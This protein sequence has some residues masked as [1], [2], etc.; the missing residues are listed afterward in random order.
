MKACVLTDFVR[1]DEAY[2]LCR[3]VQN[4][5]RMISDI[6]GYAVRLIVNEKFNQNE[7][8]PGAEI[9][10]V[11]PG[12]TGSNTVEVTPESGQEIEHLTNQMRDALSGVGVVLTH[13]L[14]FQANQ[15][16]YHVACRR[17][18]RE[19]PDIRWLHWVH[20]IGAMQEQ[21]LGPF[22]RE[23]QGPFP[24]SKLV[25]MHVE[26]RMRKMA[27]FG[28]QP[29]QTVII[30]NP[31]DVCE[32]YHPL[33]RDLIDKHEL[34]H[35]DVV[36]VYPCRLDRGK[37]PHILIEIFAELVR[38][39]MDARV[40]IAD[41]HSLHGDK[42]D[43]R[44]E[45]KTLA[46]QNGVPVYFVSE[47][48][49]D[50]R[51]EI[52]HKAIMDLFDF[53]D[54]FVHPSQSES[55]PLILP[56]AAW[57]RN[58]LCLNF[59]LPLFRQYEGH[60]LLYKFSSAVD[61]A[62]GMQ[63]ETATEYGDRREYMRHCAGGIAYTLQNDPAIYN[64]IRVRKERS[65]QAVWERHLW[66]TLA[67]TGVL[68]LKDAQPEATHGLAS[69]IIPCYLLPDRDGELAQFTVSCLHSI[70]QHLSQPYEIVII[71]NGSEVGAEMLEREADIYIH[72]DENEGY[73][74]AVNQGLAAA[75]GDWLI[76]CNNDVE[77]VYDWISKAVDAWHEDTGII[78]S[79]L[80][81]HDPA[82]RVGREVPPSYGYFMGALWMISREVYEQVGGL[83]E[84]FERGMFEDKDL[85][86]RIQATGR[87]LVKVGHCKHIGNA[88]WGKLENQDE[89]YAANKRRFEE[90]WQTALQTS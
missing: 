48:S 88:T 17:I 27:T 44:N 16:K 83:D 20:S 24:N 59:D 81:D 77:F 25:V 87:E 11:N 67:T 73:G 9:V 41:F 33:A 31:L 82:M 36:A 12:E 47:G 46:E 14:L 18:A 85:V 71:D 63:G 70:K 54:V 8:Y 86:L 45:M 61:V 6:G 43:Y 38:M 39:G 13:D 64:H 3:V 56:E 76:V 30:P 52:P 62:T 53:A 15:W 40:I 4:Q 1:H 90:K 57:K 50:A 75:N 29:H 19:R 79:H 49:E 66:P 23:I 65:L 78:S 74:P 21:Q 68:D 84:Q 60:A 35:A 28:Y 2:S 26:E 80:L 42:N 55:D 58:A 10:G 51:Y 34:Y 22:E 5:V 37:Q 72:N 32:G 7:A 69:I 89:I